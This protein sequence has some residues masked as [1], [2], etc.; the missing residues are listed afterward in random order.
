LSKE[1]PIVRFEMKMWVILVALISATGCSTTN[2]GPSY[3]NQRDSILLI[4]TFT[5]Q[6]NDIDLVSVQL[7]NLDPALPEILQSTLVSHGVF[8]F[9]NL[10]MA[11]Y[12]IKSIEVRRGG[13]KRVLQPR[14][15]PETVFL[16]ASNFHTDQT[17]RTFDC[18]ALF[19]ARQCLIDINHDSFSWNGRG[20][21]PL[22]YSQTQLD[23]ILSEPRLENWKDRIQRAVGPYLE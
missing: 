9:L 12:N 15:P 19:G 5:F 3:V 8:V 17:L 20:P 10:P 16:D 23:Q 21:W 7:Q 13:V 22:S 1:H 18:Y 4:G 11:S 2:Q 6:E 14:E